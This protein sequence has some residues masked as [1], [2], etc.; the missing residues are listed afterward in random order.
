VLDRPLRRARIADVARE[1]GVSKA[2]VSF[3]FNKPERLS[4]QTAARIRTVAE[5]L[6][7]R[8]H[9]VARMLSERQTATIGVLSPQA[10]RQV[11]SNP[12]FAAF[13]E[14]V[15]IVA[16]ERGFGILFISPLG[17]S[18]E[19]AMGRATVDGIVAV[20]LEASHAEV[21]SVR[22]AR[23]P[24]VLVDAPAWPDHGSVRVEDEAG[25]RLAARHLTALG[26]TEF[27]VIGFEPPAPLK[28]YSPDGVPGR[29]MRGYR[30]ALE[31]AGLALD[32]E[33]FVVAPASIEGGETAFTRAWEDGLRPTAVLAMS[34]ATAIGVLSG[35]RALG[36]RVPADLSVVGFDD[37]AFSRLTDPPLTTVHQPVRQKGEEAARL[38]LAALGSAGSETD[39][40]RVLPTRL[41]VRG[42]TAPPRKG[43]E[44]VRDG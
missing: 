31:E 37:L 7:Y 38:L 28:E 40:R 26:H 1:A 35:A 11:F 5:E 36:V 22:R 29:R 3:A 27:L 16:E 32:P 43:Q 30:T 25:A 13:A 39:A 21:E 15:A 33:R 17:G 34:D 14:G 8:P 9:P 12:F 19:R 6:G 2:A 18:L 44:V 23:L 10:L 24:I 20:G 4:V 42:S 41:V